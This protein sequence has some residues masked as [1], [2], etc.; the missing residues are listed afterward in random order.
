MVDKGQKQTFQVYDIVKDIVS[1]SREIEKDGFEDYVQ[2][3]SLDRF[4]ISKNCAKPEVKSLLL[5]AS[6]WK[7]I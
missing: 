4:L 5:E 1:V 2:N 3:F 7:K 6:R